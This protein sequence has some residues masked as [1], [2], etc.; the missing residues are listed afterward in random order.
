MSMS[1]V[2]NVLIVVLVLNVLVALARVLLG[3]SGRDR[4]TGVLLAGTTGA[5]ALATT[6]VSTGVSALRDVALVIVALAALVVV[7]RLRAEQDSRAERGS[8]RRDDE[9]HR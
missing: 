6:S 2:L 7:A 3:P 5:A 8:V 1:A 9:H 4:I